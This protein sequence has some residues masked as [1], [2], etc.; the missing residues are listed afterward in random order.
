MLNDSFYM[1]MKSL[2][3]MSDWLVYRFFDEGAFTWDECL[4][5]EIFNDEIAA[6]I[7]ALSFIRAVF[8]DKLTLY[9]IGL[10]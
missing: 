9:D 4:V 1:N 10:T 3:G 2:E 8:P 7:L 6:S 5:Y